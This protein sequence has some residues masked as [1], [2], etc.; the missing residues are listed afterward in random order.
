MSTSGS[1]NGAR[2]ITCPGC[3]ALVPENRFCQNCGAPLEPMNE[4]PIPGGYGQE[5]YN[6]YG[7]SYTQEPDWNN[8]YASP[9]SN[10][11]MSLPMSNQRREELISKIKGNWKAYSRAWVVAMISAVF[12]IGSLILMLINRANSM[13]IISEDAEMIL[14]SLMGIFCLVLLITGLVSFIYALILLYR[15]WVIVPANIAATSPD[16]AVGFLFIPFFNIYW[17]FIAYCRL[18]DHYDD[19][20]RRLGDRRNRSALAI[21]R[22]VMQLIPY[23]GA[24]AGPIAT[25]ILYKNLKEDAIFILQSY[26]ITNPM[27]QPVDY[28]APSGSEV[29]NGPNDPGYQRGNQNPNDTNSPTAQQ[30]YQ[31]YPPQYQGQGPD[32][33]AEKKYSMLIPINTSSWA[34][35]AGYLGLFSVLVLPAPLALIFGLIALRDIKKN[36]GTYGK[37]RA[38][39]AIIMGSFVLLGLGVLFIIGNLG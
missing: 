23:L 16:R 2:M 9:R 12:Y 18:A 6:G 21:C 26:P 14:G 25:F 37:G 39:F 4:N 29:P 11:V 28:S 19:L 22:C 36:P 20:T 35:I 30:Q 5:P 31:P 32:F 10:E 13:S 24:I 7:N 3:G 17:M 27:P 38:W 34:M 33:A 1:D 8:P 15:L